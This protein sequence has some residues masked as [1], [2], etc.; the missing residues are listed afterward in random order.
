MA[1]IHKEGKLGLLE[2]HLNQSE[3]AMNGEEMFL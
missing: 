2:I 1:K 3:G